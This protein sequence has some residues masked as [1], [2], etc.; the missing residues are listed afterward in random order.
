MSRVISGSARGVKLGVFP[1][2]SMR[3]TLRDLSSYL[4]KGR[5]EN[6]DMIRCLL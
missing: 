4:Q 3:L 1:I 2:V 5:S 6:A